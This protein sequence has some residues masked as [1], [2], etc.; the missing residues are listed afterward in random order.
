MAA[1][2]RAGEHRDAWRQPR[3][4]R[5]A[6][7]C[8]GPRQGLCT[9]DGRCGDGVWGGGGRRGAGVARHRRGALMVSLGAVVGF[10]E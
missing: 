9:V 3:D 4:Y 1:W 7:V 2:R 8:S 5:E 6:L 10:A